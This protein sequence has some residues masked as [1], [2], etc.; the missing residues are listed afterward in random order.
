MPFL[1]GKAC[2]LCVDD[3]ILQ[4]FWSVRLI[5]DSELIYWYFTIGIHKPM[6]YKSPKLRYIGRVGSE[7]AKRKW[8]KKK[9]KLFVYCVICLFSIMD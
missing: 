7:R 3:S 5:E 6:Y 9:R 4:E 8:R 2:S 1:V